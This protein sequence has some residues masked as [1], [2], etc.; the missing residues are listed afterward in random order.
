M[1]ISC[2]SII[3]ASVTPSAALAPL[4]SAFSHPIATPSPV[5]TPTSRKTF[6]GDP[7]LRTPLMPFTMPLPTSLALSQAAE[8]IEPI[9]LINPWITSL[10]ICVRSMPLKKSIIPSHISTILSFTS[11]IFSLVAE[12]M[13]ENL[14]VTVVHIFDKVSVKNDLI[15]SHIVVMIVLTALNTVDVDSLILSH[16]V[17]TKPQTACTAPDTIPFMPSQ[18]AP[19]ASL[20]LFHIAIAF[21]FNSSKFPV[22]K[23]SI[24]N[25]APRNTFLIN[26]QMPSKNDNMPSHIATNPSFIFSNISINGCISAANTSINPSQAMTAISTIDSHSSAKNSAIA[27]HASIAVSVIDSHKPTKNS[28]IAFHVSIVNS[29]IS[30]QY[31]YIKYANP[32]TATTIKPIGLVKSINALLTVLTTVTIAVNPLIIDGINPINKSIGPTTNANAA[33]IPSIIPIVFF[34]ES[35]RLLNQSASP[36]R[37]SAT[38]CITGVNAVPNAICTPSNAELSS[39]NAPPKL[40]CITSDISAAAPSESY[41]SSARFATESAPLLAIALNPTSA[42]SPII[43]ANAASRCSSDMFSVA[44][45]ISLIT[46]G[47]LRI[48]PSASYK[49][50]D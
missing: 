27:F 37:L 4:L 5:Q 18:I 9:P 20:I 22:T 36:L 31:R 7:I 16:A 29:F 48:L 28:A 15:P 38:F 14:S 50:T 10:P 13:S 8:A 39:V 2:G 19:R 44:L 33:A 24:S 42:W 32:T 40:S 6:D 46:S 35:S 11:P 41:N 25:T 26:S 1:S 34:V 3:A 12:T 45:I 47:I 49:A 21:D 43:A 23:L 17:V 30:S